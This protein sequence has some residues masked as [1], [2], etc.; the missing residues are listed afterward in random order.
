[1][2]QTRYTTLVMKHWQKV[3]IILINDNGFNDS[4]FWLIDYD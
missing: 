3:L 1:M 2:W 4:T